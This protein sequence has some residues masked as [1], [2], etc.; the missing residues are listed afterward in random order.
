MDN[1][2]AEFTDA[3]YLITEK[4]TKQLG[5]DYTDEGYHIKDKAMDFTNLDVAK[6]IAAEQ[7]RGFAEDIQTSPYGG[8]AFNFAE[9]GIAQLRGGRYLDGMTDGMADKVPASIDGTQ[10]AA[11]SDGEFVIPADVVSHLGNGSSNAGA[12]VL[13][14]MMT[15]VRKERT[16]NPNQGKQINPKQ[17][18]AKGGLAGYAH[19][20]PVQK[21]NDGSIVTAEPI[22]I[23]PVN[24]ATDTT[25][26]TTTE[27]QTGVT[28]QPQTGTTEATGT[29]VS[30]ATGNIVDDS[31]LGK[32]TGGE[33]SLSNWVGETVTG[34]IGK[35]E[36]LVDR[37]YEAY[38]GPLTAGIGETQQAAF[39]A[40]KNIDTSGAGLGSFANLD[41]TGRDAYMNPY[42]EQSLAPQLRA[43]QEEA[44]RQMAEQNIR[45]A[46][47]G[48]FG[49]SRNAIMN[50]MLQRD[51]AQQQAD[52]TAQGYDKAYQDATSRF[53]E[54]RT[55]GLDALRQ[56]AD[57]GK[58]ERDIYSES[59]AAAKEQFEQERDFDWNSLQYLNSLL[60]GMPIAAQ[61]YEYSQPSDYQDI[62]NLYQQLGGTGGLNDVFDSLIQA[63]VDYGTDTVSNWITSGIGSLTGGGDTQ[64]EPDAGNV[65]ANSYNDDGT[66]FLNFDDVSNIA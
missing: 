36:A 4:G 5:Q 26:D 27:P 49:G 62:A 35:G 44:D 58:E 19:G 50:A 42:L 30:S 60:Q 51:A 63:G 40:A 64:T 66:N 3:G 31:G 8:S 11:L 37:G 22:D 17:V 32:Q 9:G 25:T 10:P 48:S 53:G 24:T 39:D 54:D 56:Q 52:I 14:D 47:S 2:D 1:P 45:A 65:S 57:L 13:D 7:A 43:A 55:F 21:F 16:G 59:V 18:M 23:A 38:T 12:K 41:Q 46:Q 29:G 34:M 15:N 61:N 28:T 33:S 6:G 20:G